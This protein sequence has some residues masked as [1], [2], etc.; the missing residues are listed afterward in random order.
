MVSPFPRNDRAYPPK[1][2]QHMNERKLFTVSLAIL[3]GMAML[4]LAVPAV[5]AQDSPGDGNVTV[6]LDPVDGEVTQGE[7]QTYEVVVTDADNGIGAFELNVSVADTSVGTID[8]YGLTAPVNESGDGAFDN[9][10]FTDETLSLQVALGNESHDASVTDGTAFTIATVDVAAAGSAPAGPVDVSVD[11]IDAGN[12][13]AEPQVG[14]GGPGP[15]DDFYSASLSGGT[16][17]VVEEPVVNVNLEPGDALAAPD[18]QVSYT[19]QFDRITGE[20]NDST[21]LGGYIVDLAVDGSVAQFNQSATNATLGRSTLVSDVNVTD[22]GSGLTLN[23]GYEAPDPPEQ[24]TTSFDAAEVV[25]DT[26]DVNPGTST[27]VTFPDRVQ[28]GDE[29]NNP[30]PANATSSGLEVNF[31]MNVDFNDQ[32]LNSDGS[33][34]VENVESDD[35]P[36]AVVVTYPDGG[37]LV[38]AGL[39]TGT[40]AGENVDVTIEDDGGL[41]E[42]GGVVNGSHTAHILPTSGLSQSYSIGDTVSQATA[43]NIL[44]NEQ[45][46]VTVPGI[47][48]LEGNDISVGG[49]DGSGLTIGDTYPVNVRDLFETPGSIYTGSDIGLPSSADAFDQRYANLT[50]GSHVGLVGLPLVDEDD[51]YNWLS[52]I[53]GSYPVDPRSGTLLNFQRDQPSQT[54][55]ISFDQQFV[56][57]NVTLNYTEAVEHGLQLDPSRINVTAAENVSA[58]DVDVELLTSAAQGGSGPSD[59]DVII[60][61]DTSGSMGG[62]KLTQAKEGAKT[63]VDTLS[64]D[65]SVGLVEFSSSGSLV[66]PLGTDKE[67]VKTAIDNL[68]ATGSTAMSQGINISQDELET[69]GTSSEQFMIVLGDGSPNVGTPNLTGP[70]ATRA[71]AADARNVDDLTAQGDGT[72]IVSLAYGSGANEA[73][74]EDIA[75]PPKNNNGQV[76]SLDENAFRGDQDD[77]DE[78]FG[79]IGTLLTNQPG[80]LNISVPSATGNPN[81]E[82]EL[83]YEAIDP[84][85]GLSVDEPNAI[86]YETDLRLELPN[87]NEFRDNFVVFEAGATGISPQD[88][89]DTDFLGEPTENTDLQSNIEN[90]SAADGAANPGSFLV[91]QNQRVT[92]D[93]IDNGDTVDIFNVGTTTVERNGSDV[94]IYELGSKVP[95]DQ[96]GFSDTAPGQVANLNTSNLTAGQRYFVTFGGDQDNAAVLD[97][98]PLNLDASAPDTVPFADQSQTLEI[99]VTSDDTTGGDVEAWV[100]FEGDNVS[101]VVHVERDTLTGSGDRTLEV[102]PDFDL[103]GPGNY[104]VTVLHT[105]SGVTTTAEFE[106]L[107]PAPGPVIE[108]ADDVEINSPDLLDPGETGEFDRGDIV[109]IDLTLEGGNVATLTFGSEDEPDQNLEV[110]ATVYDPTWSPGDGPTDITVY[111]NTY[112]IGEGMV[113]DGAGFSANDPNWNT[114]DGAPNAQHGFF[115][116]PA[117]STSALLPAGLNPER[118]VNVFAGDSIDIYGGSQGGAVL[119]A[120]ERDDEGEFPGI[121]YDLHVAGDFSPH[122]A[123]G[124]DRDDVNQLDIE[125]RSTTGFRYWKA[126]SEGE[127]ALNVSA[128]NTVDDIYDAAAE[129]ILTPLDVEDGNFADH[130]AQNEFLIVQANTTGIEGVLKEAADR[131]GMP[132]QRFVTFNGPNDDDVSLEFQNATTRRLDRYDGS[133]YGP[134]TL[135]QYAFDIIENESAFT[136]RIGDAGPNEELQLPSRID[137]TLD[138][139]GA[140]ARDESGDT[141]LDEF[142]I[143]YQLDPATTAGLPNATAPVTISGVPGDNIVFDSTTLFEPTGGEQDGVNDNPVPRRV[144][145][146]LAE[147]SLGFNESAPNGTNLV[148]TPTN[149]LNYVDQLLTFDDVHLGPAGLEVPPVQNYTLTGTSTLA[150]GATLSLELI[151]DVGENT[152]FFKELPADAVEDEIVLT[153]GGP[154]GLTEFSATVDFN[155][156]RNTSVENLPNTE[157]STDVTLNGSSSGLVDIDDQPG[158]VLA[159]PTV[160]EFTLNDQRSDGNVVQ[161]AAFEANRIASITIEDADGNV[162]GSTGPLERELQEQFNVVLDQ[163]I[164]ENQEVTAVAEI[165]K[166]EVGETFP[167]DSEETAT[168]NVED[169]GAPFF[170]VSDLSPTAATVTVGDDVQVS[171]TVENTGDTEGTQS[172]SLSV[173]G[174]GELATQEITL[175]PGESQTVDFAAVSTEGVD[176]GSYEHTVASANTSSTGSLVIES[177]PE[178][179]EPAN[180]QIVTVTPESATAT[181]GDTVTVTATIQNTG[182]AEATQTVT[183]DIN[184]INFSSDLTLAGSEASSVSF[185]VDTSGVDPGD[186]NHVVE[187]EN[188]SFEGDLTIE[189]MQPQDDND[190]DNASDNGDGSGPGFGVA[191]AMLALLGA[192]L[193]AMRRRVDE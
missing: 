66:A 179:P 52:D 35:E 54:V 160:Q 103:V 169:E 23:V 158:V 123:P 33:V 136:D 20:F 24:P 36:A 189:E 30:Y 87:G 180:F 131:A 31:D 141:N 183:L 190:S 174:L 82:L 175:G 26:L 34:T 122:T 144:N 56:G 154:N 124:V 75:S 55:T 99:P 13:I 72:T 6:S 172:V 133:A 63:L 27:A 93:A 116:N 61:L 171:A 146:A 135:L 7:V 90:S 62:N 12:E 10:S 15:G 43:G 138:R 48:N 5:A 89:V 73:L 106:I 22:G 151:T 121:R 162:L 68:S 2:T 28:P 187:T 84:V 77:I 111:L 17:E 184:G 59:S 159:Q 44:D 53:D 191:I 25:L 57:Q 9:S 153:E 67:A 80:L 150:P 50:S 192:A 119:S 163:P 161:I 39:T 51:T 114:N 96:V 148:S 112:Q 178:P 132:T 49:T 60:A 98:R 134:N 47:E 152:Q 29:N 100:S 78:V 32:E 19:L 97:V 88:A 173:S 147:N 46:V 95:D 92:F 168:I 181:Q 14:Q 130:I 156:S 65:T 165:V 137:P 4:A 37:D 40:F 45:A 76:D 8:G 105:E 113:E 79:S 166:P 185:D 86:D 129:G 110:S 71:G 157:F 149:G 143:P 74:M 104:T 142:Y 164:T 188:A 167:E 145:P 140:F 83:V 120:G 107:P 186:Y 127:N 85:E 139:L 126:L 176:P 125:Q 128:I 64:E 38:I 101:D 91:W 108:E 21:P 41:T 102:Q 193:L 42:T 155:L 177:Q 81:I 182:E 18:D 58:N 170:Q 118:S 11:P 70:A 16:F 109:P 69:N 117:D 115:T 1:T 94:E 3:L